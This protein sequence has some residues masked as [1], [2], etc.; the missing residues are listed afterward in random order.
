MCIDFHTGNICSDTKEAQP[1]LA[2]TGE[3]FNFDPLICLKTVLFQT[4]FTQRNEGLES[5]AQT[6]CAGACTFLF[7]DKGSS[8][9]A[10]TKQFLS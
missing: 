6:D 3:I 9:Q 1:W 8:H 4:D 10:L 5:P 7:K 2:P